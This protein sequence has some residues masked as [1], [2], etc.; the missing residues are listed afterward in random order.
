MNIENFCLQLFIGCD[1]GTYGVDCKNNC[2]S[3]CKNGTCHHVNGRCIYGC[4]PGYIDDKCDNSKH[5]YCFQTC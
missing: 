3:N 4:K 2:S 1:A 5:S